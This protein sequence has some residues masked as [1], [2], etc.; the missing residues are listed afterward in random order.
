MTWP[1]LY[2]DLTVTVPWHDRHCTVTWPSLYRNLNVTVP[3]PDRHSTVTWPSQYRDLI[4]TVPWPDRHST[5]TWP[6]LY[7]D[8]T[9]TLPWPDRHST[10]TL[11]S[12]YRDLTVTVPW[13]DRHRTVTLPSPYRDL[14]VTLP[15]PDRHCPRN[16]YFNYKHQIPFLSSS[17]KTLRNPVQKLD[18]HCP[19]SQKSPLHR[20]WTRSDH[21]YP[22]RSQPNSLRSLLILP[23]LL[24]PILHPEHQATGFFLN[25]PDKAASYPTRLLPVRY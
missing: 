20:P 9:V 17:R 14:T 6:S 22:R 13:P 2:R 15:W 8:L 11:P 16:L 3:W 25:L 18:I 10:V 4:V 23:F 5:V 24:H 1:S 12:M 21:F 7:R 19:F